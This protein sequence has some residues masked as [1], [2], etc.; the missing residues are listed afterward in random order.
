MFSGL[1][2]ED[3]R[4]NSRSTTFAS[5][6]FRRAAVSASLWVV[7]PTTA[8]VDAFSSFTVVDVIMNEIGFEPRNLECTSALVIWSDDQGLLC[9]AI[10][11]TRKCAEVTIMVS[12][13]TYSAN[14]NSLHGKDASRAKDFWL[15][16]RHPG[17]SCNVVTGTE[18]LT[19]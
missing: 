10:E 17:Q 8:A 4:Q 11:S 1:D 14:I 12:S 13:Q 9:K 2:A 18:S 5:S 6:V 7:A 3:S 15:Q 19:R 16:R